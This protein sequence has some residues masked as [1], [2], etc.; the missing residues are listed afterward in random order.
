M[1]VLES[2]ARELWSVLASNCMSDLA[3]PTKELGGATPHTQESAAGNAGITIKDGVLVCLA[4][5][6]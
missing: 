2:E 5:S 6:P 4:S 1:G 3:P